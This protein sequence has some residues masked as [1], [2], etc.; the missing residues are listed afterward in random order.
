MTSSKFTTKIKTKIISTLMVWSIPVLTFVSIYFESQV[1]L[2]FVT[3]FTWAYFILLLIASIIIFIA[4]ANADEIDF[5]KSNDDLLKLAKKNHAFEDEQ[6][7]V[8]LVLLTASMLAL[9]GWQ[10]LILVPILLGI[11]IMLNISILYVSYEF[12]KEYAKAL[13][14]YKDFDVSK[15]IR[16]I[17]DK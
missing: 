6:A 12:A 14:E 11:S 7:Q 5:D 17:L 8:V 16:D 15:D 9:I 1:A 10:S 3:F 13:K 2:N 4:V